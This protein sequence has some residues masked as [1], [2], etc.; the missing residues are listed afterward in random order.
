MLPC[1]SDGRT[2]LLCI[3]RL[4]SLR[5]ISLDKKGLP[6]LSILTIVSMLS[7]LQRRVSGRVQL[8]SGIQNTVTSQPKPPYT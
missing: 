7:C 4:V 1:P 3:R 5:P 8:G 2:P 6:A